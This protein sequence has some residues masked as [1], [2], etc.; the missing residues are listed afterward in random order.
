[1]CKEYTCPVSPDL[2]FWRMQKDPDWGFD[3]DLDRVTGLWFSPVPNC[4]SLSW[5]WRCKEH[6][7]LLSPDLGLWRMLEVPDWGLTSWSWFGYGHLSLI[8]SRFELW[9][10]I[11]IL[12]VLRIFM[13]LKSWFEALE[14]TGDYWLGFRILILIWICFLSIDW[15]HD[16]NFGFLLNLKV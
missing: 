8:N 6:P 14:D 5:F 7:C 10:S 9:L 2:G 15:A 3:L 1:M 13:S 4:G 12:R 11:V 16:L